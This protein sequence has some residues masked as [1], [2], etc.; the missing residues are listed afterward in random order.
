MSISSALINKIIVEQSLDTWSNLKA[1]YLPPEYHKIYSVIDNH[2]DRFHKLPTFEELKLEVRDQSTLEKIVFIEK[3]EVDTE[4]F[5]LL[6]YLKGEFTSKEAIKELSKYIDESIAFD[7]AEQVIEGL[8][9]VVTNVESKVDI[10]K[11]RDSIERVSLFDSKE[12]IE[13]SLKLGLNAEYDEKFIFPNDSLILLGGFRGS[14]KSIVC[15]NIA[16][17]QQDMGKTAIK[18]TIE[19]NLKAELQR[20]CSIATGISHF[21]IRY[22]ELSAIEQDKIAQWWA[23]RY[24]DGMDIYEQVYQKTHDFDRFHKLLSQ[25][26]LAQPAIDFVHTP[27]LTVSKF[28]AETLKR[29]NKYDNV[30]VIIVDYINKMRGTEYGNKFEW[31]QQID[32]ADKT[33]TFAEE[34]GIPIVSPYQSKKDGSVKFA[35]D[36]LV[37]ADAAFNLNTGEDFINFENIKMRHMEEVGFTSTMD[38]MSLKVGPESAEIPIDSE[39][40]EEEAQDLPWG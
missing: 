20:Q 10:V 5:Y 31:L 16:Q 40:N 32:V 12:E 28:K 22:Q 17:Y 21:K 9:S 24:Q 34:I 18:F 36:I 35:G 13:A 19:M 37:P 39:E 38:W 30:G 11:E 27:D 29:L 3:E 6:D 8:Y 26:S 14:G 25:K 23:S 4:S 7:S 1:S 33:K 2:V 15:N